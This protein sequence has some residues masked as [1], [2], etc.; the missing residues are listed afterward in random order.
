MRFIPVGLH[1]AADYLSGILLIAA[2]WL[3]GWEPGT[4]ERAVAIGAG[5]VILLMSL[6]TNYAGGLIKAIPFSA[7]LIADV[8][9]GLAFIAAALMIAGPAHWLF[10]GMAVLAIV[11][12]LFTRKNMIIR[13]V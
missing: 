5:I 4:A 1:I 8:I 11:F 3:F 10:W 7:H 13:S 6:L 12:G 2:P 9:L